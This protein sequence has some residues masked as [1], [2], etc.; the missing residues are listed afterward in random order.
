MR[1]INPVVGVWELNLAKSKIINGPTPMTF[2][3][4]TRT[5]TE[6]PEGISCTVSAVKPDGSPFLETITSKPDGKYYPHIGNPSMDEM[7]YEPIN[8]NSL[9][10]T[11]R[12]AGRVMGAGTRTISPDGKVLTMTFIYTDAEGILRGHVTHYDKQEG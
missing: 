3:S 1:E 8:A 7:S 5:Y 9:V 12:M 2:K 10:V 11:A 4:A 6:G